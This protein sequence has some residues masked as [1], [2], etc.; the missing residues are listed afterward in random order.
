MQR[1]MVKAALGLWLGF[2][3]ALAA[4][5]PPAV[6]VEL[7]TSQGCSSCPPADAFLA[8]LAD[9]PSVLALALHV[10]Y[11]D[12]IGWADSFA[13]PKFTER[14]KS[15]AHAAGSKTIY[16]PQFIIGGDARVVGHDPG[17]V[18]AQIVD[19]MQRGGSVQLWLKREGDLVSIRAEAVKPLTGLMRVQLVRYEPQQLVDIATGENAGHK[20][21]YR[22]IVTSWLSLGNWDGRGDFVAKAPAGG[23]QPIAVIVQT[24]GF[25][26]IL[27][28][29]RIP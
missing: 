8:D 28:A 21:T 7:Y 24:D 25:G 18:A 26:P 22:N 15:Y 11:W 19:L 10:D 23:D 20:I 2:A 14:Q 9:D 5:T 4:Q 12:Y 1:L 27:A 29:A 3:G 6:V 16:T 17:A 13:D